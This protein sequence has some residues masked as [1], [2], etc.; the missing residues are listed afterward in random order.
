MRTGGRAGWKTV[1]PEDL[2]FC[3]GPGRGGGGSVLYDPRRPHRASR[4]GLA[5]GLFALALAEDGGPV[6]G[7]G[8]ESCAKEACSAVASRTS[9]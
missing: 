3:S 1:S 2:G 5:A 4:P 9:F 7:L 6:E 8:R